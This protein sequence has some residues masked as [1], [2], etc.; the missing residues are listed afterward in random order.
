MHPQFEHS[1]AKLFAESVS[2]GRQLILT[3]HSEVL[4]AALG[5]AVRNRTAG[6]TADRVAVWHLDRNQDGVSAKRISVSD[7]GYLYGW[8]KSF[9][10]V[11]ENLFHE[12]AAGLPA[13]EP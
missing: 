13:E 12:W 1:L 7:K 10:D 5:N 4:V 2:G 8:V 11:E 3:T 6:L 9:A